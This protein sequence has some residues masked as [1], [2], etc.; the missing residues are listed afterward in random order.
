MHRGPVARPRT[1]HRDQDEQRVAHQARTLAVGTQVAALE[2]LRRAGGRG[3]AGSAPSR[4]RPGPDCHQGQRQR[5]RRT[6]TRGRCGHTAE[7]ERDEARRTMTT[8]A[9][10]SRPAAT[11]QLVCDG[12]P[13]ARAWL[14]RGRAWS[15]PAAGPGPA[16]STTL[17]SCGHAG[18]ARGGGMV[19]RGDLLDA[20]SHG[21]VW[22]QLR[23]S[24]PVTASS[25]TSAAT[26]LG[27][28]RHDHQAITQRLD[29][30]GHA[31]R[32]CSAQAEGHR[33]ALVVEG[34]PARAT[35]AL[36]EPAAAVDDGLAVVAGELLVAVDAA[37]E[38]DVGRAR[39]TRPWRR[40]RP[41]CAP[42]PPPAAARRASPCRC[43]AAGGS[44]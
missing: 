30:D 42:G 31:A 37:V 40:P 9:A 29:V 23:A 8:G 12:R 44:P 16:P 3:W 6:R 18:H 11:Q 10:T 28:A 32:P 27:L 5:A 43:R 19:D 33:Q 21:R 35:A 22:G 25:V 24:V 41:A 39:P 2:Q 4:R 17:P 7:H 38:P 14:R 13:R 34:R 20:Q 1:H 26:T 36:L 15:A